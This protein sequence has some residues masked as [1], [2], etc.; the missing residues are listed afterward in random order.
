MNGKCFGDKH[1]IIAMLLLSLVMAALFIGYGLTAD[2]YEY[3]LSRRIPKSPGHH[4]FWLFN[5]HRLFL[6]SNDNQ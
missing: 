1:K 5:W 6:L 4:C 2:N 3:F